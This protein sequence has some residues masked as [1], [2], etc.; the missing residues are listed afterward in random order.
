MA[1]CTR[2]SNSE[3]CHKGKEE[4]WNSTRI[5]FFPGLE[6]IDGLSKDLSQTSK[7][8]KKKSW[9]LKV[10]TIFWSFSLRVRPLFSLLFYTH[11]FPYTRS[12]CSFSFP[13]P[14][15]H[16]KSLKSKFVNNLVV[17]FKCRHMHRRWKGGPHT[18]NM[19]STPIVIKIPYILLVNCQLVYSSLHQ[20]SQ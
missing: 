16:F 14:I 1:L 5:V 19:T 20:Y 18:K 10:Y 2:K 8:L 6:I 11:F 12:S 3:N 17:S 15:Q 4:S 7:D 9:T 13:S